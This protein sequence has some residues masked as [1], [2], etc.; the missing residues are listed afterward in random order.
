MRL[1]LVGLLAR[2]KDHAIREGAQLLG[3]ESASGFGAISGHVTSAGYSPGLKQ[4]I[5]LAL[6]ERGFQRLGETVYVTDPVRGTRK[7]FAA[8]VTSTVFLDAGNERLRG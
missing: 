2:D 4:W 3:R 8:R 6:L 1:Q 5:A 7:P